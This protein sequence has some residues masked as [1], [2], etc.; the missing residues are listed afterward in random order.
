VRVVKISQASQP[1]NG[2]GGLAL[3][4]GNA[5]VSGAS[6]ATANN[7][8][9][10]YST[11]ENWLLNGDGRY[12]DSCYQVWN[13]ALN[14]GVASGPSGASSGDSSG[15][16]NQCTSSFL[17]ADSGDP[18]LD[19]VITEIHGAAYNWANDV[20]IY[21]GSV[22]GQSGQGNYTADFVSMKS[23]I[24]QSAQIIESMGLQP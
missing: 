11:V 21:D 2:E 7:S 20:A 9:P 5:G 13:T 10:Y 4:S 16:A 14:D 1:S 23:L 8:S 6:G 24:S 15:I 22:P 3:V 12:Y 18:S 19:A 17:P